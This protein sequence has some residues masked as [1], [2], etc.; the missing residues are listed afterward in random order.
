MRHAGGPEQEMCTGWVTFPVETVGAEQRLPQGGWFQCLPLPASLMGECSGPGQVAS[1]CPAASH[2]PQTRTVGLHLAV[3]F[4]V[5][6]QF[7]HGGHPPG[8]PSMSMC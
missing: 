5:L 3:R 8:G 6:A 1:T 2:N 7:L 4:W